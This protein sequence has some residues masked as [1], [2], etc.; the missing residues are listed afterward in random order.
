VLDLV[1]TLT[2]TLAN[3]RYQV[4]SPTVSL[5]GPPLLKPWLLVYA[6]VLVTGV[7]LGLQ[8]EHQLEIQDRSWTNFFVALLLA[9]R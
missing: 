5:V 3:K 8:Y 4:N 6:F 2:L 7:Q 9:L 1:L